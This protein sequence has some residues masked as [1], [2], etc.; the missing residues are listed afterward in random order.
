MIHTCGGGVNYNQPVET[1]QQVYDPKSDSYRT[2]SKSTMKYDSYGNTVAQQSY[3][4]DPITDKMVEA[5][6]GTNQYDPRYNL[7]TA[8]KTSVFNPVTNALEVSESDN[9][10]DADGKNIETTNSKNKQ[11]NPWKSIGYQYDD[12]GL[13]TSAKITWGQ[14][15]HVGLAASQSGQGYQYDEAKNQ[16]TVTKTD[17][18]G[19]TTTQILD[20]TTGNVLEEV[21]AS[22]GVT[23][24]TYDL[25]GRVLT[26]TDRFSDDNPS[27]DVTQYIY[28]DYGK[29][30]INDVIE[31]APNGYQKKTEY[32][33][34]NKDTAQYG[35]ND[36]SDPSQ[37]VFEGSK[38]YNGLGQVV[39][40]KDALGNVSTMHYNTLGMPVET[41]DANGNDM[42]VAY[43]YTNLSATQSV[44]GI[45]A[46]QTI[47]N[48]SKKP[49]L[50]I[51]YANSANP[52]NPGYDLVKQTVYDGAGQEVEVTNGKLVSGDQTLSA[53]QLLA[54]APPKGQLLGGDKQYIVLQKLD[55]QYDVDGN[56]TKETLTAY[57]DDS[58]KGYKD[59]RPESTE[60][61]TFDYNLLGKLHHAVKVINDDQ[62][63]KVERDTFSYDAA[64]HL[65]RDTNALGDVV[66]GHIDYQYDT[67]GNKTLETRLDQKTQIHYKYNK[68]GQLLSKSWQ[69][70]NG[71]DQHVITYQYDKAGNMIAASETI[72]GG[73]PSVMK[74]SYTLN[75]KLASTTYPDGKQS[76]QKYNSKGQLTDITDVNGLNAHYQYYDDGKL[77]QVTKQGH[78]VSYTYHTGQGNADDNGQYGA[79]ASKTVDDLYVETSHVDGLGHVTDLDK[80]A[81][82]NSKKRLLNV[83]R[84]YNA[85]GEVANEHM[86]SD[87]KE[88][89]PNVNYSKYYY[90]DN[91]GELVQEKK[92]SLSM[93]PLS[94]IDYSYDSNGNITEKVDSGLTTTYHYN[95]LD[96]LV[97]YTEDG[98]TFTPKYN[99]NG[100]EVSDGKGTEYYYNGLSQLA[101]VDQAPRVDGKLLAD[102]AKTII[103][104]TYYPNGARATR[105]VV[106]QSNNNQ[107]NNGSQS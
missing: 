68:Y 39:S 9:V 23:K 74:Y 13:Q 57:R 100:D 53:G 47:Y 73:Q 59:S 99:K 96:Q 21:S 94:Q 56:V 20:A 37:F 104:Y 4:Y 3:Q 7:Q 42:T 24:Y 36:S 32:N 25:D 69:D 87:L 90:Y 106:D 52:N 92:Y 97:K 101:Q 75:G 49:L 18:V 78:T 26:K 54:M 19:N 65:L 46:N 45:Q 77:K 107:N 38:T 2:I 16:I 79:L 55:K 91:L 30:G 83:T 85:K 76:T 14:S 34:L 70:Y 88:T 93:D 29:D 89:D 61:I 81:V 67:D 31:I 22:G 51:Q 58:G 84:Q 6:A 41:K 10:L 11:G 66:G 50:S 48:V 44:N 105:A 102:G 8:S 5:T 43:D 72:N 71:G 98:Q 15:G 64:G 63:S 12:H 60:E 27:G 28:H 35:T 103:R 62:A 82:G 80:T 1:D 17:G 86:I 33:V 95:K 40:Q